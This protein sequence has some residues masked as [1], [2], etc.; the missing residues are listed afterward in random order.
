MKN[1]ENKHIRVIRS[2][3]ECVDETPAVHT[4]RGGSLT[5]PNKALDP[6]SIMDRINCG[7]ST[8]QEMYVGLPNDDNNPDFD[9]FN[10]EMLDLATAKERLA[11]MSKTAM[12]DYAKQQ[13][14]LANQASGDIDVNIN[15]NSQSTDENLS[16]N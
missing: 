10:E 6:R 7:L 3:F 9:K 13:R 15:N 14:D 12:E 8:E 1:K 5:L 4:V 11:D 16:K 2:F